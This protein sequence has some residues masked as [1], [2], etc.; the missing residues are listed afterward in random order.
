[1]DLKTKRQAEFIDSFLSML[2]DNFRSVYRE[3]L[4]YLSE[5]GDYPHKQRA[6][7]VFTCDAHNKQMAKIGFAK[8]KPFFALRFS[9]HGR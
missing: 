1:M 7:I 2:S 8:G 9:H 3:L 6:N 5:L 4:E